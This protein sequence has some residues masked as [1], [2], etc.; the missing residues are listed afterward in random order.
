VA[1]RVGIIRKWIALAE[2]QL[3]PLSGQAFRKEEIVRYR[4]RLVETLIEAGQPEAARQEL[5]TLQL[6][7]E[8]GMRQKVAEIQI[9]AKM[10]GLD[11]LLGRWISD[12]LHAPNADMIRQAAIALRMQSE[13]AAATRILHY[14]YERELNNGDLSPANFLGLAET[15]IQSGDIAAAMTTLKRMPLV[16]GQAF[17]TLIPAADLLEKY[18]RTAEATEFLQQR[19]TAVPWDAGARLRLA[20]LRS[21]APELQSI[22]ANS[23]APYRTRAAAAEALEAL[24][25]AAN[26]GCRRLSA[27]ALPL[28]IQPPAAVPILTGELALLARGNIQPSE[29]GQHYYFE[30]RIVAARAASGQVRLRLLL[31]AFAIH[32]A[33]RDLH[34]EVFR[35]AAALGQFHLA[36]AALEPS[37]RFGY[38]ARPAVSD[39]APGTAADTAKLAME[40]AAV[41]EALGNFDQAAQELRRV[42]A[43]GLTSAER[44]QIAA[45]ITAID[46]RR[47]LEQENR[48]RMPMAVGQ[49]IEQQKLVRPR[50]RS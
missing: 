10:A 45:R 34:V 26:P 22:A 2:T 14:L 24:C 49:G 29:V 21:D 40:I 27:G 41:Y 17:E 9:A 37:T 6:T 31:D 5:A 30:S 35:A 38:G 42:A 8:F 3:A 32:P 47:Q 15:D 39:T 19:V 48:Q 13:T 36:L 12:P 25:G 4:M 20:R 1:D 7:D 28:A 44:A 18:K 16:S 46:N 11:A 23:T 33:N 50:R 43:T